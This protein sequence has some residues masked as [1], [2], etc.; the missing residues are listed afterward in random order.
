ME[1]LTAYNGHTTAC[2]CV[3]CCMA[4]MEAH[5]AKMGWAPLANA[6]D[7]EDI[8]AQRTRYATPG[9]SCGTGTVRKVSAAQVA[10]IKRLLAERDTTNLVRLPGSEDIEHMSLTGARDLIER[11]LDCPM[12][13]TLEIIPA[14][15]KQ[16]KFRLSLIER[17]GIVDITEDQVRAAG[18]VAVSKMIDLMLQ[19]PDKAIPA[20]RTT[21]PLVPGMYTKNGEVYKVQVSRESGRLYAKRLVGTSW[22]YAAGA[23]R[24]L[25]TEDRMTLEQAKEYGK[26]THV[27][28]NCARE[29]TNPDSIEQGIGPICA[30]KFGA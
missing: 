28:C 11:L 7:G 1:T 29:L 2:I 4:D 25:T 16:I 12:A 10:Y 19:M 21:E 15:E 3:D 6:A 30:G 8:P 23:T 22:E 26:L 18:T 13:A 17:K 14:T 24:E 27:C 20:Q 9:Q 5:V